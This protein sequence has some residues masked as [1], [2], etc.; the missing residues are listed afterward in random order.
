MLQTLHP[1]CLQAQV[2]GLHTGNWSQGIVPSTVQNATIANGITVTIDVDDLN[3]NNFNLESGATIN[4]P[5]DKEITVNGTFTTSGTL[6][7]SSDKNDSGVLFLKGTSSG[8]V[9][10]KRG[11]LLANEWYIVTPPITG[12]TVKSFAENA[13]NDI[14]INTT[15]DPDRY[16]IATYDD[17]LAAGS[18]WVYYD[19]DVNA[20]D[21]FIAGQ[22]YSM[23]RAT[24]GE[25]TFTGTLAV[26]DLIKT[27]IAGQ[28][29][30]IG[31]PFTTYYPANKNSSSSFLNDNIGVLDANF[32]SLYIWD[33]TQSKYVAVTEL[34]ASNRSLPPGQGF[35]VKMKA[36]ETEVSFN[37]AKRST[38]PSSGD[39]DF[40]K[41]TQQPSIT[42]QVSNGKTTVATD[43]KY[44]K[45]ATTGFDT[46]FEIGNFNSTGLDIYTR[47]VDKSNSINYTIQSLPS[48][49]YENMIVPIGIKAKKGDE[50]SFSATYTNLPN[51]VDLY[52]EDKLQNL[53]IK[54]NDATQNEIKVVFEND[55]ND[56]GRFYLHTSSKS[57]S[58][59][60]I[61]TLNNISMYTSNKVLKIKGLEENAS[62]K[63]YSV[64]GKMVLQTELNTTERNE[65]SLS[66]F[67]EGIYIVYLQTENEKL[68]KKITL[69]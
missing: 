35:F 57:L 36:G 4:I 27:M 58:V 7:L 59:D 67:S 63:M 17:T 46:G 6:D 29:N 5:K 14:R 38:K 1:I 26:D 43:I 42:L 21:E 2:I 19:A 28:W 24:D 62:I 48:N 25:V 69:K 31:N 8:N 32:P 20:T 68:S 23:S 45:N 12:Q 30:A 51:G 61:N 53:F 44:F 33:D 3:I 56:I 11:G 39:T 54:L 50:V 49:N 15:P 55:V 18:K 65:I 60:N 10:Y 66:K 52:L 37:E 40:Q 41:T 47:L 9:T 64:L 16:A 13:A 34:D 22:S